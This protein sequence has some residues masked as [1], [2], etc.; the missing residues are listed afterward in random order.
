[1]GPSSE[2]AENILASKP[3]KETVIIY[4]IKKSLLRSS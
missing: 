3:G 1:M 4:P 2:L